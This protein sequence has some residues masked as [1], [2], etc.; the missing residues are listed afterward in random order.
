MPHLT[1]LLQ[2]SNILN[3]ALATGEF[4][5]AWLIPRRIN[6]FLPGLS[7]T[8]SANFVA[9]VGQN[10]VQSSLNILED[11]NGPEDHNHIRKPPGQVPLYRPMRT[12]ARRRIEQQLWQLSISPPE[13]KDDKKNE[14][15]LR[16]LIRQIYSIELQPRSKIAE[17]VINVEPT[18][19]REPN[20]TPTDTATVKKSDEKV[21]SKAAYE[22]ITDQTL[23]KLRDVLRRPD[24]LNNPLEL[25]EVLFVS[26]YLKE[27]AGV[28][29]EAL[30]R[31]SPNESGL[32]E[33][34]AWILL[35]IGNCLQSYDLPA[36]AKAYSRLIIEY[37][38]SP[39]SE[40]AKAQYK[41][42]D[43]FQ[44]DKPAALI[45]QSRSANSLTEDG[46]SQK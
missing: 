38:K 21:T 25:A 6:P 31:H 9:E 28:Y 13:S 7:D 20:E 8:A 19:R 34:R 37:P 18:P 30:N 43:W 41:L 23:R 44:N 4:Q 27:A 3:G 10:S 42:I 16:Q 29:E 46:V 33:D 40:V 32:A 14:D 39:W 1:E 45:A 11:P 22:P 35:Q 26:G 12:G 2:E 5:P 24:R 36:A 17:P 15:E